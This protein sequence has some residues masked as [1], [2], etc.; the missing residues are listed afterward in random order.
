VDEC[1]NS[2]LVELLRAAGHDVVYVAEVSPT[3]AD[4]DVTARA[5]DEDRL[6]LAEDKDFGELVFRH[7]WPVP[8]LVLSR[9]DPDRH[10]H[11]A[12]RLF[13]EI[14]RFGDS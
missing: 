6:L 8:G 5:P 10:A 14:R 12:K 11:K 1:I 2:S 7:S 4:V 9:V 13:D 3:A